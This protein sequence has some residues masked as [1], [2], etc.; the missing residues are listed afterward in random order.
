MPKYRNRMR[1]SFRLSSASCLDIAQLSFHLRGQNARL[2]RSSRTSV[3]RGRTCFRSRFVN[4]FLLCR[5]SLLFLFLLLH[6]RLLV[7]F[8]SLHIFLLSFVSL[9]W[10][11]SNLLQSNLPCWKV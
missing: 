1:G 3:R 6:L 4:L 8:H 10:N 11:W 7:I 5:F 9:G 2:G